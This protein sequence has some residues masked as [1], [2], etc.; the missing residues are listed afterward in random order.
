MKKL[1]LILVLV[2][3][4]VLVAGGA[5]GATATQNLTI[6]ATVSSVA[7]LTLSTNT[8]NF[9]NADPDVTGSIPA[10]E[11]AV[12][13][14]VKGRTGA[15]STVTLTHRAGGDLTS[16]SDTI[17]IG[18][19]TWTATGAGF[20]AGTMSSGADVP[21]GSWTGPGNHPGTFSYFLANSWAYAMGNYTVSSTYTLTVP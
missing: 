5:F 11:N 20:A 12:T 9:P 16:G 18:N 8:N 15:G 2:S 3:C 13:V 19:V 10:T 7:T 4:L 6:N 14:T 21:A 17:A 1:S